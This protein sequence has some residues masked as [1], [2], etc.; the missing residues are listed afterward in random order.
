MG[1]NLNCIGLDVGFSTTRRSSGVAC[2]N[3]GK[4]SVGCATASW[5]SR[6]E[7]LGDCTDAQ[8][9]AIDAPVL[10]VLNYESRDCERVFTL[11]CFQRRCKPGLSHVRGTGRKLRDAGHETVKQLFHITSG[12][13]LAQKFP[14][15]R[16]TRNIVEAFPNAFLG[17]LLSAHDFDHTP[18]KRGAKFD[19]LFEKCRLAHK[20]LHVVDSIGLPQIRGVL[21]SIET[22][23]DHDQR[24]ALVCLLTAAGVA[25]GRY[26]AVGNQQGGYFFLPPWNSWAVWPQEEIEVQ[27]HRVDSLEVWIDGRQFKPDEPLPT[28]HNTALQS[29]ERRALVPAFLQRDSHT[30][31]GER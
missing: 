13:D 2:L 30:V 17:V 6:A 11:G 26:T 21:S 19:W 29:D 22:N 5:E 4:L 16:S 24:A 14:R 23:T 8:I 18:R 7:I 10:T 12:C 9:V 20:I 28:A 31:R 15:V 1:G 27:R 3:R 25:A